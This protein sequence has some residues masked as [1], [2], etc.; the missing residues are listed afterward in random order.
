MRLLQLL[1]ETLWS[2]IR[3]LVGY[4]W[5]SMCSCRSWTMMCFFCW[6][7]TSIRALNKGSS[8]SVSK[9][10]LTQNEPK[11][12]PQDKPRSVKV[13]EI[14]ANHK[15]KENEVGG[16]RCASLEL[17]CRETMEN[18]K[19]NTPGQASRQASRASR[20][21]KVLKSEWVTADTYGMEFISKGV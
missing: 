8:N 19:K 6:P 13:M 1:H 11:T 7:M 4:T 21:W 15:K 3:W 14:V 16:R 2:S 12:A 9:N 20:L 17:Q 18:Q 10:H 5:T